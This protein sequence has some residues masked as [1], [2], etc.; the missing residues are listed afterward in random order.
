VR[1]RESIHGAQRLR[2]GWRSTASN[3]SRHGG[4]QLELEVQS[5]FTGEDDPPNLTPRVD[6]MGW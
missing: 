5:A 3:Y 2:G 4:V 1:R 6:D